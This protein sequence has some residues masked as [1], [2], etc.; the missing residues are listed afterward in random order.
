MRSPV[1]GYSD[2]WRASI[3]VRERKCKNED[4][5]RTH[6][7]R[8]LGALS[9]VFIKKT[10]RMVP[11]SLFLCFLALT[12]I[13]PET[14]SVS[15]DRT[16]HFPPAPHS[17]PS[18]ISSTPLTKHPP[19]SPTSCADRHSSQYLIHR[20]VNPSVQHKGNCQQHKEIQ[21]TQ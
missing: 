12:P 17:P 7:V 2:L 5:K 4:K 11:V 19:R 15:G 9:R 13:P 14:M 1:P 10:Q 21:K 18:L 20:P 16:P 6:K 3:G 8:F